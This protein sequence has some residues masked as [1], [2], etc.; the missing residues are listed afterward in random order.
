M[1]S[2][3]SIRDKI[4]SAQAPKLRR[5]K[6][7]FFGDEVWVWE[8]PAIERD[9][10]EQSRFKFDK[11]KGSRVDLVNT[12]AMLLVLALRDSGD[13][14]AKRVFIDGDEV[15]LGKMPAREID[16]LFDVAAKLAGLSTGE[17]E[18]DEAKKKSESPAGDSSSASV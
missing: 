5:V 11:K 13:D 8:L 15:Q 1:A 2:G 17:D 4:F 18:E 9:R 3:K 6:E 10:Y 7:S 12:R 14:D 16:R